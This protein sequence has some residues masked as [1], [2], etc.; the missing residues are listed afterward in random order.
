M[1]T[2]L[3]SPE[4]FTQ[5]TT[6]HNVLSKLNAAVHLEA[7]LVDQQ[8]TFIPRIRGLHMDTHLGV[9]NSRTLT[10]SAAINGLTSVPILIVLKEH[11]ESI[12]EG[13]ASFD[14]EAI[15]ISTDISYNNGAVKAKMQVE[16][17]IDMFCKAVNN[18]ANQFS[19]VVQAILDTRT[20]M[21]CYINAS[22]EFVRYLLRDDVVLQYGSDTAV[23]LQP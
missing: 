13:K 19:S 21:N 20:G 8:I 18:F 14:I 5:L 23:N 7:A 16:Y 12:S 11:G 3:N 22:Q 17:K 15:S 1:P 6:V 4:D 9:F 10:M 2:K